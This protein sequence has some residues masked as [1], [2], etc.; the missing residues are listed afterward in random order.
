MKKSLTSFLAALSV[1]LAVPMS[2]C[3]KPGMPPSTFCKIIDEVVTCAPGAVQALGRPAL[4][5]ILKA[6]R[7]GGIDWK[8]ALQA[9]I[10]G[11]MKEVACV[12]DDLKILHGSGVQVNPEELKLR[13]QDARRARAFLNQKR[14]TVKRGK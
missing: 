7:G 12:L 5:A 11:G 14:I 13:A 2:G 6:L 1:F 9:L 10:D 4:D 8:V 3:C